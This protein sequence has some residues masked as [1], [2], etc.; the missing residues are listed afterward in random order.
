MVGPVQMTI[1]SARRDIL[2]LTVDNPSVKT[3]V[4]MVDGVSDP[5]AVLVSMDSLA[6]SVK[7]IIGR[8]RVSLRSTTRCAKGN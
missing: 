7:E 5:T 4:R 8:A 3:G 6:H 2:E 1:A